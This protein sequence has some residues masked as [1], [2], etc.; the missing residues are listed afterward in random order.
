MDNTAAPQATTLEKQEQ[1]PSLPLY[2]AGFLITLCGIL[3]ANA[4]LTEPD[5][6]WMTD[7][8]M[9]S[10]VG[11]LFSYGSRR[12]GLTSR[13]LDYGLA[14]LVAVLIACA[15][16]RQFDLVQLLPLGADRNDLRLMSGLV[17]SGTLWAWALRTD[18]RVALTTV[19][20]MAV[21]G[22][23]ATIDVNTPVLVCFGVFILA[24]IFLLIHQN[25]L[26]NKNRATEEAGS[27]ISPP[28]RLLLAQIVQAGLCGLAVLLAGIV[29][30]V[31]AQAVFS[32]LSLS[33]AIRHLASIQPDPTVSGASVLR[34]S[35]DDNLSIGT[36]EAW[37]SSPEVVMR[38][39]PSDRQPH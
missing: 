34:F 20:A 23:A 4:A 25:Y 27:N 12:L 19:P 24:V 14:G 37:S 3:A 1:M 8:I 6:G 5:Y 35:D 17:W 21:L 11:F 38:V 32:H 36:G 28:K 13:I 9:L 29:V 31:P 39:T 15:A 10:G 16:A 22:M 26:Q 30:I 18:N 7:T 33:Q 2:A